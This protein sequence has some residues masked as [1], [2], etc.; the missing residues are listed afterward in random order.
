LFI[1]HFQFLDENTFIDYEELAAFLSNISHVV[2][3]WQKLQCVLGTSPSKFFTIQVQCRIGIW[4][5][6]GIEITIT[7]MFSEW[8]SRIG[9]NANVGILCNGTNDDGNL[10][11]GLRKHGL[12]LAAGYKKFQ[13][14][15]Y[16]VYL[17]KFC[18]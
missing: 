5:G 17:Y 2:E 12:Y 1:S 10:T 3:N 15:C 13:N 18:F 16:S 14:I 9:L 6:S 4:L 7:R 11:E 8:V